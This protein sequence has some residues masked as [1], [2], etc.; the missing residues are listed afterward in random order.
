MTEMLALDWAGCEVAIEYRWTDNAASDDPVMV[1]LHEGLGSVAMW[2]DFPDRLCERLGLR[3]LVYSRPAYGQST[4]RPPN[5]RWRPDFEQQ[6]FGRLAF[7]CRYGH[8]GY[9]EAAALPAWE[10]QRFCDALARMLREEAQ[11]TG[12]PPHL[13][14]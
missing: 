6:V 7:M 13:T 1:F 11:K 4:P 10:R 14:G 3:G 8:L 12:L 9:E 5:E 2:K